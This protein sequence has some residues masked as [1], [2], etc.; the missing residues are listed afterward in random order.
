MDLYLATSKL[1]LFQCVAI[2]IVWPSRL[3]LYFTLC[4]RKYLYID[5]HII[6]S[7]LSQSRQMPKFT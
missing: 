5:Q 3:S 4:L 7:E 1:I 6:I 2:K